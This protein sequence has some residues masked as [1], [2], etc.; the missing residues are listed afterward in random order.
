MSKHDKPETEVKSPI[1]SPT[2][3]N[4]APPAPSPCTCTPTVERLTPGAGSPWS[5]TANGNVDVSLIEPGSHPGQVTLPNGT[6][7][8]FEKRIQV[9][10][11]N[12]GNVDIVPTNFYDGSKKLTV[13]S[14]DPGA[15]TLTWDAVQGMWLITSLWNMTINPR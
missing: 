13:L 9:V 8:G 4:P 7:D 11:L 1:F 14:S 10:G 12:N 3:V 2:P 6:R 15:A 5:L